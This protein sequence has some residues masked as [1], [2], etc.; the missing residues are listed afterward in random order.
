MDWFYMG[1]VVL[2]G[3]LAIG[4]AQHWR[5]QFEQADE[6][7]GRTVAII[8]RLV[9]PLAYQEPTRMDANDPL[10]DR[11]VFC[12]R[13]TDHGHAPDCP[14]VAAVARVRPIERARPRGEGS[15]Q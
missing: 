12:G 4:V 9:E 11:L 1:V 13:W 3:I 14:W 15:D 5:G 7:R 2:M 8:E 6:R 10:R